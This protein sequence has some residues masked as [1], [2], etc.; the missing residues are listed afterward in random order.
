MRQR[1]G[2]RLDPYFSATKMAWMLEQGTRL[3]RSEANPLKNTLS[4]RAVATA[5]ELPARA[6]KD[7]GKMPYE[8][9]ERAPVASAA[10]P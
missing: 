1:T 8:V 4:M 7:Y 3:A 9:R 6:L 5:C 10:L 2:L